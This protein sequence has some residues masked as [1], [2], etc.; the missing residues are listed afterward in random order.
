[1]HDDA[2]QGLAPGKRC[3]G[4]PKQLARNRRANAGMPA[5]GNASILFMP[6]RCRF[7]NVMEDGCPEQAATILR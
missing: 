3:T 6:G 7:A 2:A 1:M 4:M 5:R